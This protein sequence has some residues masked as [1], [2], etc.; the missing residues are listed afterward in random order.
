MQIVGGYT[1]YKTNVA[2]EILIA[3]KFMTKFA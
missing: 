3:I 1:V 2:S